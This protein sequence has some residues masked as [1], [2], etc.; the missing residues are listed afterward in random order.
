MWSQLCG[1]KGKLCCLTKQSCANLALNPG[2]WAGFPQ[3]SHDSGTCPWRC[4]FGDHGLSPEPACLC[5]F[6]N[7]VPHRLLQL[8]NLLFSSEGK[9]SWPSS[10]LIMQQQGQQRCRFHLEPSTRAVWSHLAKGPLKLVYLGDVFETLSR[11]T[12]DI[13]FIRSSNTYRASPSWQSV[14]G[15][16]YSRDTSQLCPHGHCRGWEE[17]TT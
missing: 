3:I 10:G 6:P 7:S 11:D 2:L 17:P 15:D 12:S 13:F 4:V 14:L 5:L 9:T 16:G 8:S 1:V